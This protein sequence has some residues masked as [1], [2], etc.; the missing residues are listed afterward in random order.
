MGIP[1]GALTKLA[2]LI[3]C[4]GVVTGLLAGLF[5][6][7]GGAIIVPVLYELFRLIG[8]P[9]DV[10]FQ[11]CLGT[12]FA[13]IVPTT[14]RSYLS[15]RARGVTLDDV[16]WQWALPSIAGVAI[17]SWI[18]AIAPSIVFKIVFI[19]FVNGLAFK[20]LFGSERWQLGKELPGR[21]AM[22]AYGVILGL[23][24]ALVGVAGGSLCTMVLALYGKPIHNAVATG[25]GFGVPV[26]IAG[27]IGYM[28][29]G[30]PHQ[31]E[32]PPFSIG[33]VS[34]IGFALMAPISAFFA[35]YGVRF[36]HLLSKRKLEIAFGLFLVAVSVR[37]FVS[38]L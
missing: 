31:A 30:W 20:I 27:V 13:I 24:A 37:F 16:L 6:I 38:L 22:I 21:A 14:L 5:G 26:T 12:S 35:G 28:L 9:E 10:R 11:L 36:A 23:I 25:A 33:F 3:G 1:L 32:M 7:G 34:L 19:L 2:V 29:A 4:G 15:H 17:G 18:A 8:V